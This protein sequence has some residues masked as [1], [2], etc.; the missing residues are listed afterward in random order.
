MADGIYCKYCGWQETSHEVIGVKGGPSPEE[1]NQ[2]IF[3][4]RVTLTKCVD[5]FGFTPPKRF[6]RK[7]SK[8]QEQSEI[9]ALERRARGM[10]AWGAYSA[11]CRQRRFDEQLAKITDP[12][13]REAFIA[14]GKS[15]NHVMHVGP[16]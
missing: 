1:A 6:V 5:R 4:R 14:D 15:A 2:R 8:R 13:A 10:V 7:V 9:E 12:Q 16:Y 11:H 3:G